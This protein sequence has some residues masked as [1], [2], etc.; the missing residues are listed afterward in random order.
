MEYAHQASRGLLKEGNIPDVC[1]KNVSFGR[2]NIS[3][4][5]R[6]FGRN[7]CFRQFC[8]SSADNKMGLFDIHECAQGVLLLRMTKCSSQGAVFGYQA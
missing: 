5:S 2:L 4:N 6:E 3:S 8:H 1:I 7:K